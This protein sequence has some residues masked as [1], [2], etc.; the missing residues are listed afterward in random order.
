[1]QVFDAGVACVGIEIGLG[2]SVTVKPPVYNVTCIG[3]VSW[4]ICLVVEIGFLVGAGFGNGVLEPVGKVGIGIFGSL[5]I[6]FGQS[7]SFS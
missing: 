2:F 3:L 1:M 6:F 5:I 7:L 4:K